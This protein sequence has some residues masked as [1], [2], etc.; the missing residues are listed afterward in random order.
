[1]PHKYTSSTGV[2]ILGI[3]YDESVD[4]SVDR[5]SGVWKKYFLCVAASVKKCFITA[6]YIPR[7]E[8]Q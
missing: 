2:A 5:I 6:Y 7:G 8:V 3:R 1:M 4:V